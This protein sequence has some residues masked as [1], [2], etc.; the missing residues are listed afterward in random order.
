MKQL[1]WMCAVFG[2]V[3]T[4]FAEGYASMCFKPP[5]GQK[6]YPW[7]WAQYWYSEPNSSTS[8]NRVPTAEDSVLLYSSKNIAVPLRVGSDVHAETLDLRFGNSTWGGGNPQAFLVEQGGSMTNHGSVVVGGGKVDSNTAG[9]IVVAGEW[10]TYSNFWI[11]CSKNASTLTITET[12]HFVNTN[13]PPMDV[14]DDNSSTM[15]VGMTTVTSVVTNRGEMDVFD[16]HCGSGGVN[17]HGVVENYGTVRVGRK[18]TIGRHG[19]GRFHLHKGGQLLKEYFHGKPVLIGHSTGAE[20]EVQFDDD[21]VLALNDCIQ[22]GNGWMARGSLVVDDARLEMNGAIYMANGMY[23]AGNLELRGNAA[24]EFNSGNLE[25]GRYTG[26]V[27]R[28]TLRDSSRINYAQRLMIP[29]GEGATGVVEVLDNACIT[30]LTQKKIVL[31]EPRNS[32]GELVIG[33]HAYVGPLTNLSVSV[34]REVPTAQV[35]MRGGTIGLTGGGAGVWNLFVGHGGQKEVKS[36]IRGWGRIVRTGDSGKMV[37]MTNYGQIIADGEGEAADLDFHMV[38]TVGPNGSANQNTTGSNGWYAVSRGRLLYP[39]IQE[40]NGSSHRVVGD[41][42]NRG[43]PM[44]VNSLRFTMD[45]YP[46]TANYHAYAEL[47]AAD[48]TDYPQGLPLQKADLV[49]GVWRL[50]FSSGSGVEEVPVPVAFS[51]LTLQIRHDQQDIPE[52]YKMDVWHHDGSATGSW[53]RVMKS[54]LFDPAST[55]LQ[56]TDKVEPSS[57]TWNAGWFAV[58]A[59]DVSN[60]SMVLIR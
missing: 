25:M 10:N 29:F 52:G 17:A 51:G 46:T 21:V 5:A 26:T 12:G 56:T 33:D 41:Y 14:N 28:V 34:I 13:T 27:A 18:F 19:Y 22:M 47:Y 38:R 16:L 40:I 23:S 44:L 36:R 24:L 3:G 45:T 43:T 7:T 60:G 6:D 57:E 1:L 31:G 53:R 20:G 48:R 55:V 50:G 11:G 9:H 2:G 32:Y 39:R 42:P 30:N 54:Q 49:K 58:T 35:T 15:I 4:L 8:L 37:R 59:R